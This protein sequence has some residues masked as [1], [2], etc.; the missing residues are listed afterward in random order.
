MAFAVLV[1][2]CVPAWAASPAAEA[3]LEAVE[4]RSIAGWLK[5]H[6]AEGYV[7]ADLAQALGLAP[8]GSGAALEA[9]QRGFRN[10]EVLRVAQ[11]LGDGSM[12]FMVQ[13]ADG[14]VAF[15]HSTPGAGLRRALVSIPARGVVLPLAGVEAQSRFRDEVLYWEDKAANR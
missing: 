14:E 13:G 8:A 2:F 15:Y 1:A 12:V 9:R 6:G 3:P 10:A 11:L 4:L 5:A 7:G